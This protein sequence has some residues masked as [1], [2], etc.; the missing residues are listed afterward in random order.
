[1]IISL[2]RSDAEGDLLEFTGYGPCRCPLNHPLFSHSSRRVDISIAPLSLYRLHPTL[3]WAVVPLVTRYSSFWCCCGPSSLSPRISHSGVRCFSHQSSLIPVLLWA[4]V[5]LTAH[6]SSRCCCGPLSL[7]PLIARLGVVVGRCPSHRSSLLSVLLWA[8]VPLTTLVVRA[9]RLFV[10]SCHIAYT[11][12][13][14]HHPLQQIPI[15]S[16][17][18]PNQGAETLS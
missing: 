11:L 12:P 14:L 5:P 17:S 8:I 1:M 13:C 15:C 10:L 18:L 16:R 7:S 9:I 3:L 2:S 6:R 4:V